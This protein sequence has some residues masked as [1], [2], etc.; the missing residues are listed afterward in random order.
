MWLRLGCDRNTRRTRKLAL[1]ARLLA[2]NMLR[3][4]SQHSS[5]WHDNRT[6][7]HHATFATTPHTMSQSIGTHALYTQRDHTIVCQWTNCCQ[8]R[9]DKSERAHKTTGLVAAHPMFLRAPTA[10]IKVFSMQPKALDGVCTSHLP[11][12]HHL[13][14]VRVCSSGS[15][16]DW[17]T[18]AAAWLE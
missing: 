4:V 14:V 10:V 17:C 6:V 7:P 11:A 15:V 8:S 9:A 16:R 2:P 3:F 18:S 5:P 12:A 1:C 13:S